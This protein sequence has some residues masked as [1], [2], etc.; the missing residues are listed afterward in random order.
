M[1]ISWGMRRDWMPRQSPSIINCAQAQ[2]NRDFRYGGAGSAWR[3]TLKKQNA[4]H[5]P[6]ASSPPRRQGP[7]NTGGSRKN[8]GSPPPR[9]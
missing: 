3:G 5:D 1:G 7:R 9:G 2:A 6:S 8:T 4:R